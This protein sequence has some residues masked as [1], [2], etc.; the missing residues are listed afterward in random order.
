MREIIARLV[1]VGT[2]VLLIALSW[3][4]ALVQQGARPATA[5]APAAIRPEPTG[6]EAAAVQQRRTAAEEAALRE[7]GRALFAELRCAACHAIAG[8]GN[9]RFPL[10]GVAGRH[11]PAEMRHWIVG[12]GPAA[13]ALSPSTRQRKGRFRALP[14]TDLDALVAFLGTL[15][16]ASGG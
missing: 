10:D 16:A 6:S 9:P 2:V 3:Q 8:E 7:R 1:A 4:F 5:N 12:T 13:G 11:G 15:T 14:E